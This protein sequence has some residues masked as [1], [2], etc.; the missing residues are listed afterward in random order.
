MDVW[1]WRRCS[2]IQCCHSVICESAQGETE[3]QWCRLNRCLDL[4]QSDWPFLQSLY[5]NFNFVVDRQLLNHVNDSATVNGM[6]RGMTKDVIQQFQQRNM[7]V[8]LSIGGITY[9]SISTELV[10]TCGF[11][12]SSRYSNADEYTVEIR[13]TIG[14]QPCRAMQRDWL[15]RLPQLRNSTMSA[16]KLTMRF[17]DLV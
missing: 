14:T 13:S 9:V 12:Y 5:Y 1:P 11:K 16:L 10:E 15:Q 7:T 6:P 2:N 3:I 4:C 17:G 8:I